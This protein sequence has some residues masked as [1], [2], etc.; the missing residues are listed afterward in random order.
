MVLTYLLSRSR[1]GLY[2]GVPINFFRLVLATSD[3]IECALKRSQPY[4]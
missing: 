3:A 1:E 2:C 4:P